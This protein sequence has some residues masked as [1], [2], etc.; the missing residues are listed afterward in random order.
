VSDADG[1]A[2][3]TDEVEAALQGRRYGP[4]WQRQDEGW[5][6]V[7][8]DGQERGFLRGVPGGGYEARVER[9]QT[10]PTGPNPELA[11]G[12]QWF[13]RVE[14]AL[15]YTEANMGFDPRG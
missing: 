14:D 6:A 8:A 15:D 12:P 10:G 4:V 5:T 3:A 13:E 7:T 9:W 1:A 2:A 11:N